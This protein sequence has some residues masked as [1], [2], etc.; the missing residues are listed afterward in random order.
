MAE[1]TKKA[2][3]G[4]ARRMRANIKTRCRLAN[5]LPL[6]RLLTFFSNES[7]LFNKDELA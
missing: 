4:A 2:G 7:V 3:P 5:I 6:F 1:Y